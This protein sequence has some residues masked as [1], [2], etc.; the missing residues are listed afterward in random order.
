LYTCGILYDMSKSL[1][2][3]REER[4]IKLRADGWGYGTIANIVNQEFPQLRE[5]NRRQVQYICDKNKSVIK[6]H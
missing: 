4:I 3:K 6:W 2:S 1:E 5:L